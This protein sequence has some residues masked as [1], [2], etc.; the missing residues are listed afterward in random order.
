ME[1]E[2]QQRT[3]AARRY[4]VMG[5]SGSGKS[6]IGRRLAGRLG[7]SYVEGD[8]Y[9]SPESISK[10]GAGIPLSDDDRRDW[11]LILQSMIRQ[12]AQGSEGMVLTCSALK[13]RY[14]DLLREGDPALVFVYL[15]GER[16]LIAGRMRQR[17]RHFMPE[18]LLDSQLHDL[19]PPGEDENAIRV[20]IAAQPDQIVDCI[21]AQLATL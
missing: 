6:E 12:A 11:L 2:S 5:V 18:T 17:S 10:M 9:H 3:I 14:R 8:D 19:E 4:V 1:D 7:V 16:E 13:R 21:M 20:D 15:H